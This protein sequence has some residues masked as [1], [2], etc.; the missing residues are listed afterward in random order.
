[1]ASHA[2]RCVVD[3]VDRLRNR[4]ARSEGEQTAGQERY[5]ERPRVEFHGIASSSSI[6][7]DPTRSAAPVANA[8]QLGAMRRSM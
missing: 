6:S 7:P 2:R 3:V 8:E 4:D 1:M 5:G